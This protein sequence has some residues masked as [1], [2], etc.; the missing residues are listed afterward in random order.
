VLRQRSSGDEGAD[1][2]VEK[3]L[4]ELE[5]QPRKREV[6]WAFATFFWGQTAEQ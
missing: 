5:F 6:E 4:H 3:T 1:A 2:L